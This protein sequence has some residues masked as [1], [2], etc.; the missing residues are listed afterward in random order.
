MET[1]MPINEISVAV[2][3]GGKSQRFGSSK[4]FAEFNGKRLLDIA[5]EIAVLISPNI[6]LITNEDA[7]E[8]DP[9]IQIF[10][11]NFADMGPLAGVQSALQNSKTEWTAV[12]PVDMPFL[13]AEIYYYLWQFCTHEQPVAVESAKGLEPLVSIWPKAALGQIELSLKQEELGIFRCLKKLKAK[14]IRP[15]Q[16]M[17]NYKEQLFI[18]INK[19]NDLNKLQC[20]G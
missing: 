4:L 8:I 14:I 1:K 7:W 13:S 5:L 9:N 12:L 16:E 20:Q 11:D 15:G 2:I 17:K 3:A 19:Q 18:N 10:A 6:M